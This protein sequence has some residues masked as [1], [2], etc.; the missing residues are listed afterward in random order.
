MSSRKPVDALSRYYK[1]VELTRMLSAEAERALIELYQKTQDSRARDL[2]IKGALRYVIAEARK[3]PRSF[4]ERTTLEDLIAAGNIGLLRA[5]NKFDV[6]A[7][8]RFLTY[9][10]WWVRH[11]MREE[12]R[13][14]GLVHVP[15]HALARGTRPPPTSE[16]TESSTTETVLCLDAP[17]LDIETQESL[18]HLFESTSLTT[19]EI[20]ILKTSYGINTS[21]K[22]LKQIGR[23]LELTGERV[24]QLREAAIAKLRDA[25]STRD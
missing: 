22:T 3:H 23:L 7:G 12:S 11:E 16:Y 13:R 4:A 6:N 25:A 14:I 20:F 19:R 5:L 15:A 18:V 2:I 1:E 17:S 10:S 8:T 21:P 9:A 24:R